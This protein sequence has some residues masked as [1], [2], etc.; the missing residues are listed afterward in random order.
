MAPT[1]VTHGLQEPLQQVIQTATE[2]KTIKRTVEKKKS[3]AYQAEDQKQFNGKTKRRNGLLADT[4]KD[5]ILENCF[6]NEHPIF[7]WLLEI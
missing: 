5:L 4:Q 1:A 3:K 7:N 2:A 6:E